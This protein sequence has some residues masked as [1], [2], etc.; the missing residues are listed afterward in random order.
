MKKNV[1]IMGLALAIPFDFYA[2]M[3][4]WKTQRT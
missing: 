3:V 2:G 4:K 1:I